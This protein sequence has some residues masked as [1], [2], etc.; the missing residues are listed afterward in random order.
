MTE[1]RRV[2]QA[3]ERSRLE[4]ELRQP[5]ARLNRHE[6]TLDGLAQAVLALRTGSAALKAQNREL[7]AENLRLRRD[8]RRPRSTMPRSESRHPAASVG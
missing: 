4:Q 7:A 8:R 3:D 5:R 6:K 2:G 1:A